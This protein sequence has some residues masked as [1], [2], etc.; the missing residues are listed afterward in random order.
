M[1]KIVKQFLKHPL[2]DTDI[3]NICNHEANLVLNS[4]IKK[5]STIEDLVR[6]YNACIILYDKKDKSPGH[7]SCIT[8][9]NDIYEFFCPYG[10]K[11]DYVLKYLGGNSYL[12][13]LIKRSELPVIYNSYK[14]QKE[15]KNVNTCGRYVG[16]RVL[17]K[18]VNLDKFVDML[19]NNKCYDSDFFITVLTMFCES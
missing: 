10:F 6:P 15:T 9:S 19:V 8:K 1:E 11:P 4:Q 13:E 2:S 14:L 16:M 3:L 12:T 7:W 17:L 18:D 5:Y